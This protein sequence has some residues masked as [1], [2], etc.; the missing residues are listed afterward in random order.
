VRVIGINPELETAPNYECDKGVRVWRLKIN[1]SH[2]GWV[3]G[4]FSIY[5]M[6]SEWART[7]LIDVIEL[8]DYEGYAAGWPALQAPLIT[9]LHGS[10]SY[11]AVEMGKR[12]NWLAF[13]LE[14][15]SL[16]RSNFICSTSQYTAKQ[17]KKLF[18]LGGR[19]VAVLYNSVAIPKVASRPPRVAGKVV[20]TGTLTGKK[21]IVSLIRSW[22][23]VNA[24]NPDAELH[25]FGKA[26]LTDGG[27]SMQEFLV[28]RLPPEVRRSVHF[29]GHVE[30][31]ELTE[32]FQTASVA[33]FP[34]YSE[35][36]ALGPMEAMAEAC[37]T[38]YTRR[39]SGTELIRDGRDGLLIDPDNYS[40]I[41]AA[42]LRI[43]N[44]AELAKSLGGAGRKRIEHRFSPS[45]VLPHNIDFYRDCIRL[46]QA[47]EAVQTRATYEV[48]A[49]SEERALK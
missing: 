37:P 44:D 46:F 38:I 16:R 33:V 4:R 41:A 40:E 24:Q 14:G 7:G 19:E 18:D 10:S 8:P 17:T 21:G 3:A 2:L 11:F 22:V 1:T 20:F 25:I 42:I 36:F 35:A 31:G 45:V 12:P 34:S 32:A 47:P 27:G 13:R 26:G 48:A 28:S 49:R 9:R 23:I 29:H 6:V 5:R 39:S 15:A 30:M 43:L